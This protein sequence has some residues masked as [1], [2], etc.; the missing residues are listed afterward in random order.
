M[1]HLLLHWGYPAIFVVAFIEAICIP[2]PSEI[3]F[4]FTGALAAEGHL[5]L[6]A[7]IAVGVG[8]EFLGS[9]T[10]YVIGRTGGRALAE[11]H[12]KYVLLTVRDIDRATAFMARVGAPAV[13]VGRMVPL[14]RA[15]ISLV[16]G[17][18]E[19]PPVRFAL[20]TFAGGAIYGSALASVGYALGTGWHRIVR[21]FT[22]ASLVVVALVVVA[23]A[24]AIWHRWR[25]LR[26]ER[27]PS[28]D[29]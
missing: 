29:A 6:A 21:G 8:G 4:G 13:L 3:T 28:G 10:A 25:A 23:L 7:V 16:A 22:A 1:E 17:I 20:S 9:L 19:M 15:F 12:G 11:R 18:G 24:V 27:N 5:S 14:L 26:A 2:F